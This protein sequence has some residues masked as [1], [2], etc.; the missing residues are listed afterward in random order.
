MRSKWLQV[1]SELKKQIKANSFSN[2][3]YLPTEKQLC[4]KYKIARETVRKIYAKLEKENFVISIKNQGRIQRHEQLNSTLKSFS[5]LTNHKLK[6]VYSITSKTQ[7]SLHL[8]VKRY[9]LN[10]KLFIYARSKIYLDFLNI[11]DIKIDEINKYGIMFFLKNYSKHDLNEAVKRI[12]FDNKDKLALKNL[13]SKNYVLNDCLVFDNFENVLEH[14]LN[15][16]LPT[17]FE[18]YVIE[19]NNNL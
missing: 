18:Y 17:A 6:S 1:Y 5:D 13:K 9:D 12:T 11:T 15:Y 16:Y 14:S 3:K 7:N 10:N 2:N 4:I 8:E 19:K